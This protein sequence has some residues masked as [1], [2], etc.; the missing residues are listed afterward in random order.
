MQ[1]VKNKL[2]FDD[3]IKISALLWCLATGWSTAIINIMMVITMI[4]IVVNSIYNQNKFF[5]F[6]ILFHP[7]IVL[8]LL[9]G[10]SILWSTD[11]TE[12]LKN[13]KSY[14]PFLLF[15]IAFY[16]ISKT[17]NSTLER[18]VKYLIYSLLFA[19]LVTIVWNLF[20]IP[21][22]NYLSNHLLEHIVK[23]F[24]NSNKFLFGW[25][26][27]FMERIHFANLLSLSGLA[28]IFIFLKR[29][30]WYFI[31]MALVLLSAPFLLGARAAMIG[32]AGFSPFIFIYIFSQY[33]KKTRLLIVLFTI[34][35]INISA[36]L[37]YPSIKSRY[38]Q[39]KYELESIQSNQLQEKDF[40]HFATFTRF[41][42]WKIAW[43]MFKEKPILGYGIGN[44]LELYENKYHQE[45]EDLPMAYHSQFLYFL[46][47][48]GVIGLTLFF[49]SYL[50]YGVTL[51]GILPKIYFLC[52]S[53]YTF[54]IWFFDTGLLQKKEMMAFTLFLCF[55]KWLEK[56]E[57]SST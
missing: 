56:S 22:A 48:F 15:P 6:S 49:L 44:Y 13:L 51:I 10:I 20:P 34:I 36:Y 16:Y 55:A 52:F 30:R 27:P 43:D 8:F 40:V 32:I 23:P 4:L 38:Q 25:Y 11:V 54:C 19:Y 2:I 39:T 29:K 18:G 7:T 12:S 33:S 50:F 41:A 47:V 26:V 28:A 45:Y 3:F 46:G 31:V 21:T 17:D 5:N 35:L 42:S 1:P 14:L 24:T 9:L 53:I 37:F 57:I